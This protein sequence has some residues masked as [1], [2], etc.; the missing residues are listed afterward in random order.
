VDVIVCC[1]LYFILRSFSSAKFVSFLS[2]LYFLPSFSSTFIS[3]ILSLQSHS[4][5]INVLRHPE[6]PYRL[7]LHHKKSPRPTHLF[8]CPL[9]LLLS[10]DT[11]CEIRGLQD[12][13]RGPGSYRMSLGPKSVIVM[14]RSAKF[15]S[16]HFCMNACMHGASPK[17]TSVSSI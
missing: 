8:E 12:K 15:Q 9:V 2:F 10:L 5:R 14:H 3:F 6:A 13:S 4:I 1:S 7:P 11:A 17:R 16:G